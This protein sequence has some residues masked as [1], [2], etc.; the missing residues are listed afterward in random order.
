MNT[1]IHP[2]VQHDQPV[3]IGLPPCD[4]QVLQQLDLLGLE[5]LCFQYFVSNSECAVRFLRKVLAVYDDR[6]VI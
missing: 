4:Q 5:R 3:A 2:T 1:D 6:S